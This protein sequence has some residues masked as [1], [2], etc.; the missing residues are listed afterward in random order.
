MPIIKPDQRRVVIV[1]G[2][3]AGR[4]LLRELLDL[5]IECLHL[6]SGADLPK[7]AYDAAL[8]DADLGYVGGVRAAGKILS[9]LDPIAVVA[10]SASG[11]E[12]AARLSAHLHLPGNH[13]DSAGARGEALAALRRIQRRIGVRAKLHGRDFIVNTVSWN[14]WHYVAGAWRVL[15]VPRSLGAGWGG[16]MLLDPVQQQTQALIEC[17]L[18][19]LARLG[20]CNGPAYCHLLMTEEG[21]TAM[22]AASCLMEA[23]MDRSPYDAAGMVTQARLLVRI[24]AEADQATSH[25]R[26]NRIYRPT[27]YLAKLMFGCS[28]AAR[29]TTADGLARLRVLPSLSEHCGALAIGDEVRPGVAGMPQGGIVYLVHDD[30]HH[31]FKDIRRF[32]SWER[33]QVLYA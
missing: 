29:I 5:N 32:R 21:L 27:R 9:T 8:Y 14:D 6:Q 22:G 24:L 20:I 17:A 10:G 12:L 13:P 7:R 15:H 16:L 3:F 4:A 23:A 31:I 33:S 28:E 2:Y 30:P 25:D 26:Y 1:D 19:E 11:V 18:K